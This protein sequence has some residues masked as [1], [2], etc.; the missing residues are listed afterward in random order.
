MPKAKDAV[1]KALAIDETL[2]EAHTT[3]GFIDTFS[4]RDWSD[5]EREFQRAIQLNP[6]YA[7]AH[8]WYCPL[9][10]QTG[11]IEEAIA[12]AK[13]ALQLDPVSVIVNWNLGKSFYYARR[14]DETI[15][16]FRKT[17]DLD[18]NSILAL[19]DSAKLMSKHRST[20][21]V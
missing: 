9:L 13:R 5:A 11:R 8:Q 12:E 19:L 21:K 3:L 10:W 7:T 4:E 20:K 16:Q 18:P 1:L 6:S 17:L 2:A 15:E 14:Y